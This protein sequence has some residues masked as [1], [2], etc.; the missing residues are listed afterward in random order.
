MLHHKV[1]GR[2][3]GLVEEVEELENQLAKLVDELVIKLV[4]EVTESRRLFIHGFLAYNPRDYYGKGSAIVYT[5]WT[6]KMES[7]QDMSG[8]G[9]NQKVKYTIS[10]FIDFKALIKE[11]LCPNNE[12]QKLET[13]FR[14]HVI[15]GASHA[16]YTDRFHELARLVPH[17]V[18][19]KNKRIE[20]YIYG[21][22]PQI[23]RMVAPTEPT[24]IQS[25][26]LKD[27][28]LTDKAIRNGSLKKNTEKRGNDEEPSRDGNV[29]DE[30]KRSRTGKAFSTTTNSAR[31]EYMGVAP[32]CT[33]CNF[34]HHPEMP[35]RTCMNC[36]RLGN[37]AKDCRAGPRMYKAAC[38]RLNRATGQGGNRLN[39]AIAIEGGQGHGNNGNSTW[40]RAFVMG[41][42]K[43]RQ[44]PNIV[45]GMFTLNNHYATTL[46]D[47]GA[48]YSFVSTTFIP[49]L[50][51][52][53][54]NLGFSYEIE[55]ASEQLLKINKVIQGC[56]LEIEG[57]TFDINL[58]P[59]GHESFDVILGMDWLSKHNAKIIF[60][61]KV[62]RI[63]LPHGEMLRV[64]GEQPEEKVRQLK[65]LP[66]SGEIK[67]RIDLIPRAMPVAKS[68]YRLAPSEMEEL[69][70]QL[71]ELQDKGIIRPSSSPWGAPVLFVKKK[72][73]SFKMCINNRELN[74]LTIK[75]RYPLPKIDDLFDQLQGLQ[76][77]S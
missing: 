58:I 32:K 6:E 65:R 13:E 39:Q 7:V 8:C 27:G 54:S 16:A 19:P 25:A 73:G 37:F 3:D 41:A 23:H 51:V 45:T 35:C 49:L 12:M 76:Y 18:T 42:E 61:K 52:E 15:V 1:E 44:D 2:V 50:D 53:P 22:A 68:P 64:L 56:K 38:P 5:H 29:R 30:K 9:D 77:F 71:R 62:V 24:I 75:N 67:F 59:F 14:C 10:S 60:L 20:R 48:D 28:M 17:L 72:D 70:S 26:I 40:G 34:H 4:K 43:A 55:K 36:N 11:E 63:P 66:P 31:R 21:L 47:S 69:S 33:N 46:F 74:K 57:H